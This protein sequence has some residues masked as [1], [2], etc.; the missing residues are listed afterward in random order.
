VQTFEAPYNNSGMKVGVKQRG[1]PFSPKSVDFGGLLTTR[2][3][4]FVRRYV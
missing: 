3:L 4:A 1:L 2:R